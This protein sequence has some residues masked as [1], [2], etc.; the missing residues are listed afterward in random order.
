MGKIYL[1]SAKVSQLKT[2]VTLKCGFPSSIYCLRTPEGREMY[3]CNTLSDYQ[4]D[5]G[6]TVY[7][8]YPFPR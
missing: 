5:I 6:M 4:L 7:V 1:L 2:L 8:F 3:D